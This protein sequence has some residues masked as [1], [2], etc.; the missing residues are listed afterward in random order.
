MSINQVGVFFKKI[1]FFSLNYNWTENV[2]E[3]VI[4][5]FRREVGGPA[6]FW[7]IIQWVAVSIGCPER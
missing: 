7:V 4:S 1:S 5:G 2:G 3:R 6:L